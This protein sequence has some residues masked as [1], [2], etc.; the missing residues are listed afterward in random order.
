[1]NFTIAPDVIEFS[2]DHI[3]FIDS[4]G[5]AFRE[6]SGKIRASR[7]SGC[8]SDEKFDQ[9]PPVIEVTIQDGMYRD[10]QSFF[11]EPFST[12]LQFRIVDREI[13][14]C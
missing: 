11:R 9:L 12:E 8:M 5:R 10:S 13:P 1:M 2:V 3:V 7:F 4:D 6:T 14:Q